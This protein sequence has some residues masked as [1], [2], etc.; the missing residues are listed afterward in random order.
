VGKSGTVPVLDF[1]G[2]QVAPEKSSSQ[3][4]ADSIVAAPEGGS[5]LV[6]NPADQMI[7]YYTEGMAAPMGSFQNYR[8]EP[9]AVMVWDRSLREN[10]PGIYS[11]TVK[12]P[13]SG[14]Y[15][16]AFLL[17]SP[18]IVNCFDMSVKPNP[19]LRKNDEQVP[20]FIQTLI[21]GTK[22]R[23]GESFTLQFKVIDAK[24]NQPRP[25]LKDVG[26]LTFLAPGTWQNRQW[27]R[28]IGEGTYEV[29]FT[30]PK[31]GV[32]YVFVQCPSLG[33]RYNQIPYVI[34]EAKQENAAAPEKASPKPSQNDR[35]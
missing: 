34:L 3:A 20:I 6:A 16:V 21:E 17:D 1:P 27:A 24:T 13:T 12:L 35:P 14:E 26:V 19:E 23:T 5:V 8:R 25:R 28:S 2:G 29:S 10:K 31:S 9:R 22:I 33:V 30:P 32:Y 15:D 4:V 18:R 11:T 7:Y